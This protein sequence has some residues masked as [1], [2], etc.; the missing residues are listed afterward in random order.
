M[1]PDQL[2][3]ALPGY[4]Y[5]GWLLVALVVAA[6]VVKSWQNRPQKQRNTNARFGSRLEVVERTLY[7]ERMRRIQVEHELTRCGFVLPVWPSD[8]DQPPARYVD[9]HQADD[10]VDEHLADDLDDGPVTQHQVTIPPL[11]SFPAHRRSAHREHH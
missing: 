6:G 3:P 7:L 8:P 11:G 1:A 10:V 5:T 4:P 2:L 9:E